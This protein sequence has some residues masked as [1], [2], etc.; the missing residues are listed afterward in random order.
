M[1]F[2][3]LDSGPEGEVCLPDN[4]A[5]GEVWSAW[6]WGTGRRLLCVTAG[7]MQESFVVPCEVCFGVA[8]NKK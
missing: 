2:A 8:G 3:V 6:Q 4:E 1:K 5:W 7:H